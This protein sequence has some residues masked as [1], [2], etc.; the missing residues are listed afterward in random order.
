MLSD[1]FKHVDENDQYLPVQTLALKD[2]LGM[3]VAPRHLT[4]RRPHA[5]GT[6]LGYVP[7]HGGDVWWVQHKDGQ[8]GAYSLTELASAETILPSS[9]ITQEEME[10]LCAEASDG[11]LTAEQLDELRERRAELDAE[12]AWL[13]HAE[14]L[15]WEEAMEESYRESGLRSGI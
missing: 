9:L 5:L 6:L 11:L 7:G 13:K 4:A 14:N 10:I 1:P 2:T 15:G 12:G 8:I 3:L